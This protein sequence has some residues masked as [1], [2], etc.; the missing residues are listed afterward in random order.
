MKSVIALAIAA[1]VS[2]SALADATVTNSG[3]DDLKVF[4]R[5]EGKT[6]GLTDEV[7]GVGYD[8][9][10]ATVYPFEETIV[11]PGQTVKVAGK[12][13]GSVVITPVAVPAW[14]YEMYNG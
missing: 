14:F 4:H 8:T 11:K 12:V 9:A 7:Y 1:L 5:V 6:Y 3:K 10:T 2:T 13:I